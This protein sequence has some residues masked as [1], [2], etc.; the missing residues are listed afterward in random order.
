MTM[1]RIA[2]PLDGMAWI[3]K[4]PR[5][6]HSGIIRDG[7]GLG[8][9]REEGLL[10]SRSSADGHLVALAAIMLGAP[11]RVAIPVVL[12]AVTPRTVTRRTVIHA[13]A[14]VMVLVMELLRELM[15]TGRGG[16]RQG[17]HHT[18][19]RHRGH[20]QLAK[21]GKLLREIRLLI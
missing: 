5:S 15:G 20:Q 2:S 3:Q 11:F 8:S 1:T 18:N 14:M 9:S 19:R 16:R 13:V 10:P 21:H 4:P 17:E 6:R 7:V 12:T